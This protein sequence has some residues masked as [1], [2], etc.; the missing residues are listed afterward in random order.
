MRQ[1]VEFG[2]QE[3]GMV[4]VEVDDATAGAVTRGRRPA[5]IVTRAGASLE[6]VLGRVGPAV[7]GIVS[8]LRSTADWPDEVEV[9]FAIKLSGDA[10]VIIA[11]S[12]GEANFRISLRWS[13]RER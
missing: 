11:R 1:L 2:L 8:E 4:L 5:E 3:G 6:Q 13:R 12:G 10:N 9:E 7:G